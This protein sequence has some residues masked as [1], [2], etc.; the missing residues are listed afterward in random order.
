MVHA[1]CC[2]SLCHLGNEPETIKKEV[3]FWQGS[4]AF[5]NALSGLYGLGGNDLQTLLKDLGLDSTLLVDCVPQM[6]CCCCPAYT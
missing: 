4:G 6:V 2:V 1:T 3:R 5:G